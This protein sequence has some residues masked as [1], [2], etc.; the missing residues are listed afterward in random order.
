MI[1]NDEKLNS[2]VQSYLT[3]QDEKKKKKLYLKIIEE[4]MWVVKFTANQVASRSGANIED[5]IQVGSIGLI[6]AISTCR[7]EQSNKFISYS[8]YFI[9]GEMKHYLRD[10]VGIIRAPREIQ[11]LVTR[12]SAV[13]KKMKE[14]G[15][16]EPSAEEVARILELPIEKVQEVFNI[17]K[18]RNAISL[19][20]YIISEED[21]V[22]LLEKI[23]AG[24]YQDVLN[25]Y[26]DRMMIADAIKK[27]PQDF[28][29]I[30]K[31]SYYEDMKLKEIAEKMD[32]SIMQV[33]RKLKRA[34]N[35]LYVLLI[36]NI[37]K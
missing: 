16:E 21:D 27:L 26:E 2:L 24:D 9:R 10:K 30:I 28:Q 8:S 31:L 4:V 20:Q 22:S 13:V 25:S 5:L 11:E 12:I 3:C 36:K 18:Y 23:P 7:F 29:E 32:I 15:I 6:K 37:E 17:D 19:D 1:K 14:D 33:S 34:L 35:R